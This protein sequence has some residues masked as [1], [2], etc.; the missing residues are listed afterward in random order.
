MLHYQLA[1]YIFKIL[2]VIVPSHCF[3]Y[4][5]ALEKFCLAVSCEVLTDKTYDFAVKFK[6]EEFI[7][8]KR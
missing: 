3:S 1:V 4:K 2:I 5:L 7:N 6:Q 8:C